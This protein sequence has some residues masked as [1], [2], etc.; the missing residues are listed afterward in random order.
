MSKEPKKVFGIT[1][2]KKDKGGTTAT[3]TE[4]EKASFVYTP[5]I[6]IVNVIPTSV[7]EKYQI[8]G[9][10]RKLGVAA[11]CVAVVLGGG[12]AGGKF[13][14]AQ[15]NGKLND[16]STE[17]SQ[18]SSETTALTP[19]QAYQMAVDSKRTALNGIVG[20][21]VNMGVI[22]AAI[23]TQAGEHG[24]DLADINVKQY[25]DPNAPESSCIDPDPFA[26]VTSS[27]TIIGCIT[28]KGGTPSKDA[29]NAFLQGL[30]ETG[31]VV[32][33]AYRNPFISSFSSSDSVNPDGDSLPH[34]FEGSISFTSA[35]YTDKYIDLGTPL[36]E[37]LV[38]GESQNIAAKE[39]NN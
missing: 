27:E 14:I 18:I 17:L 2:G 30:E 23:L 24:L 31:G 38:G 4:E 3:I 22:Y 10:L 28:I 6:P 39:K 33:N 8:K 26:T 13:L 19:Y 34:S 35:L 20:S 25:D 16:I 36:A 12:Y 37:L 32:G 15:E 9:I 7:F 21:D 1:L 5:E 29:T 11:L